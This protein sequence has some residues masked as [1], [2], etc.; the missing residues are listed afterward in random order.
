MDS[1]PQRLPKICLFCGNPPEAKNLEHPL[2]RWLLELTGDPNRVVNFG[3][4][5]RTG[6]V[7]KFAFDQFRFPACGACNLRWSQFEEKAKRVVQAICN[8]APVSAEDYVLLLDWLDKVRIGVWL[9]YRY[10]LQTPVS[11]N[12]TIEGRLGMKDRMVAVYPIG[13]HQRGLNAHGAET[14]LFQSK[15]SVF[16]LRINNIMLLNASWDWMCS[17]ACGYPYPRSIEI[18]AEPPGLMH[19]GAFRRRREVLH[20]I[21]SNIIKPVVLLFQPVLASNGGLP[22][23]TRDDADNCLSRGWPGRNGLGPLIRQFSRSTVELDPDTAEIA[24]DS[25]T[26]LEARNARDI[27]LQAYDLQCASVAGD[28]YIGSR[29]AVEAAE[30]RKKDEIRYNRKW[31]HATKSIAKPSV[32]Y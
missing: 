12:F 27:A 11:P 18:D 31:A 8:K 17:R 30:H 1:Q 26:R 10:L 7:I 13:D 32:D 29:H 22:G 14:P 25:V 24:F 9:G 4:D 3:F 6:N 28:H 23:I 19:V 5:Y 2:P 15:P 20:P 16:A 21:C